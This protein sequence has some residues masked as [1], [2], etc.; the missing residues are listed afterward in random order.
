MK[1]IDQFPKKIP[2]PV[3]LFI[4]VIIVAA[5]N[6]TKPVEEQAITSTFYADSIYS[7]RETIWLFK[8]SIPLEIH[9]FMQ[10]AQADW[11]APFPFA[12]KKRIP[13]HRF[14]PTVL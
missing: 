2:V 5:C 3:Y 13:S 11:I 14:M 10:S 8:P 4:L 12:M 6:T 1:A 9:C 7:N